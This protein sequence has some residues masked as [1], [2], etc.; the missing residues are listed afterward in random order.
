VLW[1]ATFFNIKARL[2]AFSFQ[3]HLPKKPETTTPMTAM[4]AELRNV[5]TDF[6]FNFSN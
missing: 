4:M 2:K 5:R 6:S 1:K 3:G